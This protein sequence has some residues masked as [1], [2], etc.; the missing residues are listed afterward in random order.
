MGKTAAKKRLRQ[1]GDQTV[2]LRLQRRIAQCADM[3]AQEDRAK[4]PRTLNQNVQIWMRAEDAILA[5]HA[6]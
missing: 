1:S 2:L 6:G 4:L 5:A 3:L